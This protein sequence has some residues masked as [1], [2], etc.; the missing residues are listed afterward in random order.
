MSVLIKDMDMPENCIDCPFDILNKC[1]ATSREDCKVE[2]LDRP[3][4]CPLVPGE[5]QET[6]ISLMTTITKLT[7]VI[8]DLTENK[9]WRIVKTGCK[10]CELDGTMD[11]MANYLANTLDDC[12]K[13]GELYDHSYCS[14]G[15]KRE[16]SDGDIKN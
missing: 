10:T 8:N 1:F 13:M 14:W 7:A 16:D 9:D 4:W 3:E 15:V 2:S 6:V 11:C 5:P 12:T